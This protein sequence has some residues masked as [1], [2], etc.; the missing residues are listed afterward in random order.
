M[1]SRIVGEIISLNEKPWQY[2]NDYYPSRLYKLFLEHPYIRRSFQILHDHIIG[3]GIEKSGLSD[4]D[5][6]EWNIFI[7]DLFEHL[8]IYGYC[9][10]YIDKKSKIPIVAPHSTCSIRW[11]TDIYKTEIEAINNEDQLPLRTHYPIVLDIP[12]NDGRIRSQMGQIFQVQ[13]ENNH[14]IRSAILAEESRVKPRLFGIKKDQTK[15]V[16]SVLRNSNVDR[17]TNFYG[18]TGNKKIT[19][20]LSNINEAREDMNRE[21][22]KMGEEDIIEVKYSNIQEVS[23]CQSRSDLVELNRQYRQQICTILGVPSSYIVDDSVVK[24][25]SEG[26]FVSFR[27]TVHKWR[28]TLY[29]KIFKVF[30]HIHNDKIKNDKEFKIEKFKL[31]GYMYLNDFMILLEKNLIK[32]SALKKIV[33]RR[34]EIDEKMVKMN[35]ID[36]QYILQNNLLKEDGMKEMISNRFEF[37]KK[38]INLTSF[39]ELE[40]PS[41]DE[42]KNDSKLKYKKDDNE[43]KDKKSK[44]RKLDSNDE[45]DNNSKKRKINDENPK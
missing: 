22:Y 11:R 7:D 27:A 10:Y 30:K 31:N 38:D 41:N 42:S 18:S 9:V 15:T 24:V 5:K 29:K 44:K 40:N 13:E 33:S 32:N 8:F 36:F 19:K 20:I 2:V 34:F 26:T 23:S 37:K 17:N 14:F 43:K 16:D 35:N 12:L 6:N 25:N 21:K 4:E 1:T 39:K 45:V 28:Q 3:D